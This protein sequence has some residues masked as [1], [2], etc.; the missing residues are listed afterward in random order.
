MRTDLAQLQIL[1]VAMYDLVSWSWAAWYHK[2]N[3]SRP[4]L[5][6]ALAVAA[7]QMDP[8]QLQILRVA[9]YELIELGSPAHIVNEHVDLV[10]VLVFP[11]AAGFTNGTN[12]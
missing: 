5:T 6:N 9:L 4:L 3:Q 2:K 1:C 7:L 11:Q 10:K 8:V 12:I